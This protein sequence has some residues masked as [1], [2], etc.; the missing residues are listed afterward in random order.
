MSVSDSE[1]NALLIYI[2]LSATHFMNDTYPEIHLATVTDKSFFQGTLVMIHSFLM[3]NKWFQG[4]ILIIEDDLDDHMKAMLSLYP[5]I[6]FHTVS[7][8]LHLS[9]IHI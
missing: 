4:K 9:L 7:L 8:D 2:V 1:E 3:R 6:D 5:G